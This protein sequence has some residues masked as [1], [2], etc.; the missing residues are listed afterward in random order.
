MIGVLI[1]IVAVFGVV[2]VADLL[3]SF[4]VIRRLAAIQARGAHAGS[5]DTGGP[6]IGHRIG[7]FR[8]ELLT[9]GTFTQADLA[10]THAFVVFLMPTC[11]PCKA[12]IA[13]LAAVRAPLP[14]PLYVLITDAQ[15]DA[16]VAAIAADMPPGT[17]IGLVSMQDA[18]SEA[19]GV[20]GYP[21]AL[22]IEDGVVRAS[23]LKVSGLLDLATQ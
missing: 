22:A 17:H 10:G 15:G 13:E 5:G 19:F 7:D 16:D 4:A 8:V 21:T 1:A 9:G 20:D 23:E 12:A 18:T 11:E 14:A 6:A 3:L 2:A